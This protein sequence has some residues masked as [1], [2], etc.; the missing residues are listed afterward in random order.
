MKS[1][2]ITC[3]VFVNLICLACLQAG[4]V[5][6]VSANFL[7]FGPSSNEVTAERLDILAAMKTVDGRPAV[8]TITIPIFD[9]DVGQYDRLK[10]LLQRYPFHIVTITANASDRDITSLDEGIG[11]SGVEFLKEKILITKKLGS[12][13]LSGALLFPELNDSHS[14]SGNSSHWPLNSSGEHIVA[15][16]LTELANQRLRIAVG[17]MQEVADFAAEQ[18]ITLALEYITHWEICGCNTLSSAIAFALEVNRPNFG[19]LTDISHEVHQ[20][21]GPYIYAG[22]LQLAKNAGVPIFIQVSEPGRGEIVNSWLPFDQFFGILQGLSLVDEEHPLDVEIFDA[23]GTNSLLFQLTRDP[24]PDPMRVLLDG[25]SYTHK[26]YAEVPVGYQSNP[27]GA[28][29]TAEALI[30]QERAAVYTH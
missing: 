13:V 28:L 8:S 6:Y 12:K 14:R 5:S 29:S 27:E 11:R 26:R 4:S 9:D 19:I 24:F 15:P 3:L 25:I 7:I 17:R 18:G 23:K 1:Y 10:G 21:K 22:G 2:V 16:A 20:G 30:A